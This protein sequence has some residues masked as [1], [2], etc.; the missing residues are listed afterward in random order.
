VFARDGSNYEGGSQE[1]AVLHDILQYCSAF[2]NVMFDNQTYID[3]AFVL[4]MTQM[5]TS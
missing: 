4:K 1:M 5:M 2:S 3:A